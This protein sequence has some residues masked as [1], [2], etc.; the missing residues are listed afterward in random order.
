MVLNLFMGNNG[1]QPI[2]QR[3]R[4]KFPVNKNRVKYIL[5]F[6]IISLNL[7]SE[8]INLYD[9][10]IHEI[11]VKTNQTLFNF[12]YDCFLENK[13]NDYAKIDVYIDNIKIENAGLRKRG[14]W[15]YDNK[16]KHKNF[17]KPGYKIKFDETKLAVWSQGDSNNKGKL[18]FQEFKKNKKR[19]FFNVDTI[20]LRAS[21]NDPVLMREKLVCELFN[22]M[23]VYAPKVGFCKLYINNKYKGLYTIVEQIDSNFFKN[24]NFNKKGYIYKGTWPSEFRKRSASKFHFTGDKKSE[25]KAKDK[26]IKFIE[27]LENGDFSN[28]DVERIISYAAVSLLTGHWDSYFWNVNNDYLYYNPDNDK[29]FIVPWDMDNSFGTNMYKFDFY[30]KDIYGNF[31]STG[32]LFTSLWQNEQY[33][34]MFDEKI[35]YFVENYY[36]KTKFEPKVEKYREILY[37]TATIDPVLGVSEN[38]EF[39]FDKGFENRT[40]KFKNTFPLKSYPE[41]IINDLKERYEEFKDLNY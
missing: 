26:K 12:F 37:E 34:K 15:T 1:L 32:L 36:N 24:R 11:K 4:G 25:D 39:V 19:K 27:Q 17:G 23:G 13:I 40:V 38:N 3:V 41:Y 29:W 2:V 28:L 6:L 31:G 30:G 35:K 9:N 14:N 18:Y 16:L 10:K 21:P 33:K 8:E 20:N 22:D 5:M 7:Y